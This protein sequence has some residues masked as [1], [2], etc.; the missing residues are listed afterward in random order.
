VSCNGSS[1]L[2]SCA[3]GFDDCNTESDN[4]G[5]CAC[6]SAA[7]AAQGT[8]GGCCGSSCQTQHNNGVGGYYYDCTAIGTYNQ[9]QATEAATSDTSQAGTISAS[10][11][12]NAP[13]IQYAIF[14]T[15]GDGSTGTCTGW[16]YQASGT[17]DGVNLAKTVGTTYV[18]TG[19]PGD[20]GCYCSLGTAVNWN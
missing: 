2:Y 1:C 19:N 4:T 8:P 16:V 11:C 6:P 3:T 12:G 15:A 18:S 9:T 7:V 10:T 13:N 17:Y 5:G 20:T 14:K